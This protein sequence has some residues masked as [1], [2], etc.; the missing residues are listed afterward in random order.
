M[1][2]TSLLLFTAALLVSTSAAAND[3]LDRI[4]T[5]DELPSVTRPQ[6]ELSRVFVRADVRAADPE[7]MPPGAMEVVVARIGA[8][9]A[10]ELSCVDTEAA[11]RAFFAHGARQKREVEQK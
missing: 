11:A 5:P 10:L 7:R 9:G 3:G 4:C 2:T 1:K 6:V 8:D